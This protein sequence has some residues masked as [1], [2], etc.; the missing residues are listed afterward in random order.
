[1][2][3]RD[4]I[5]ELRRVPASE[6]L[7]N[8]KNWRTHPVAQ[9]DALRGV[10][11]EVGYA[12]ALIARETP[13]GLMLID[14]HLR[15]ETTPDA[16]VPVLVLDIDEAES[17]LMLATLDP[18]A[19]MAGQDE[20]RLSELLSTV[21]SDNDT[22]NV[23]LQT[24]A[25]GYEPLTLLEPDPPDEGFDADGAMDDVEAEDYVPF[26]ER[27]QVWALG[28]HRIVC[29]DGPAAAA[30][31]LEGVTVDLV[32]TD[33]PYGINIVK[34]R[35]GST[36]GAKPFGK[37]TVGGAG[38]VEPRLYF[39]VQGDDR[40]FDPTWILGMGTAQIIFGA[41][42]FS[43]SLPEGTSWLSWDKQVNADAT[44]SQMELAWTS[45]KGRYRLYQHRWSGMVR[46]G[47]R[48]EELAERIHPTQ[49]P[50]GLFASIL[51]DY[52]EPGGVVFDPYSGSGSTLIAAERESRVC[53]AIDIE[54][55]YVDV[56]IKRWEDYTGQKAVKV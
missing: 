39:P 35:L 49:K 22:V 11:A 8:P 12:D 44:F 4:R 36:D 2:Q 1:M 55:R 7:P 5:K 37:G 48:N 30:A 38:V 19:A 31:F 41:G 32:L 27:G 25:N 14:G 52:T 17:D 10:L 18:L 42:Y 28:D 24:L 54:P 6:L 26:S 40:P 29:A 20:E 50:V 9:Q 15:A 46:E 53:Y 56:A 21:T 45:V 3:I 34:G 47:Q 13:E 16:T 33:P 51:Q 23:L 43:H